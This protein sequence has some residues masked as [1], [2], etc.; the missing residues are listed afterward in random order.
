MPALAI[1]RRR[2]LLAFFVLA[3]AAS[4]WP[5][6]AGGGLNPF[7]PLMA[8]AAVSA[9]TGG[10]AELR[11]WWRRVTRT[12]GSIG[13]YA[14]AV[15]LPFGIN[16]AAA[17]LAVALGAPF[18]PADK[19]AR[20]PEL[21]VVFPLYLVAFGPLGE[22]PGW[23]GFAMPRLREGR[24][25]LA[26]SL[27]LGVLVAAWHLPL[28][29]TG[30]QPLL[31]LPAIAAAQVMYTWLAR[32]ARES[33]LIVMVAHAAQGGL[34][35][36]YFGPMFAGAHATLE[37]RLLVATQCAVALLIA[38]LSARDRRRAAADVGAGPLSGRAIAPASPPIR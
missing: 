11:S 27:V 22:E 8:A 10:K 24:S 30:A 14:L 5:S 23:R 16:A 15:A 19:L 3:Y 26:A 9:L 17:A 25:P 20:W 1:V 7:G 12:G 28:V 33:V 29:A 32:P 36:E 4:W 21:L 18:P 37:T 2:P 6:L 38:L 13:W 35:G 34:G 31:I